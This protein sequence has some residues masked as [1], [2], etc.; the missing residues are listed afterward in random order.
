MNVEN[1]I[2]FIR[3]AV[4]LKMTKK[5]FHT[6]SFGSIIF[7]LLG[8]IFFFVGNHHLIR[9]LYAGYGVL[10]LA[11]IVLCFVLLRKNVHLKYRMILSTM[12][13]V[14]LTMGLFL[15][16]VYIYHATLSSVFLL[17]Y[18]P[19]PGIAIVMMIVNAILL[20]KKKKL[21]EK[22]AVIAPIAVG[23]GSTALLR[24]KVSKTLN[25]NLSEGQMQLLMT[26]LVLVLCYGMSLGLIDL[27]RF[28]YY[29][30]LEKM[31]LVTEEILKSDD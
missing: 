4:A 21:F 23:F 15:M 27:Q 26:C 31:G 10:V 19:V 1:E 17:L 25:E 13:Y 30:K 3:R 14:V 16:S 29:N 5:Q 7:F 6:M 28:Y 20:K 24:R 12:L 11:F 18:L 9:M 2:E 8:I 22:K